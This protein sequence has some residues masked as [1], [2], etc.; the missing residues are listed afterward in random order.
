MSTETQ[1]RSAVAALHP[2]APDF[3]PRIDGYQPY[4]GQTGCDPTPKPGVLS[5][6]DLLKATY[7]RGDLG[8]G[9]SCGAEGRSEHKEG[10]A[11]DYPFNA[12]DGNQRAQGDALVAWLLATD[13]WNNQHALARRMGVMYLIWNRRIWAANT[14]SW[15]AYSGSSPHTDHVHISFGWPGARKQTTWWTESVLGG[16]EMVLWG[17]GTI[18]TYAVQADGNVYGRGQSAPG[19]GFGPWQQLSSQG[20][21][22]GRPSVV[23]YADGTISVYVRTTGGVVMGTGNKAG[24][25]SDFKP[26]QQTTPGGAMAVTGDPEVV[27]RPDG[28]LG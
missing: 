13:R 19:A 8:I 16:P 10:R 14:K 25:G 28:T 7:G 23:R 9:R 15:S 24:P 2:S 5:I 22:A 11:L 6:R 3:G 1:G 26:W 17:N 21:F 27:L 18:G 12:N 4:Q 20:G